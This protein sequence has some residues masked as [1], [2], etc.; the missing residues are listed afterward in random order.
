MNTP[1]KTYLNTGQSSKRRI[2][3]KIDSSPFFLL[4]DDVDVERINTTLT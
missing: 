3:R 2:T 4:E 1:A